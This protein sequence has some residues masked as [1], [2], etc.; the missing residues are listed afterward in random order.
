MKNVP[1]IHLHIPKAAGNTLTSL[2]RKVFSPEETFICGNNE[3]GLNHYQ[4]NVHFIQMDDGQ[5]SR[6]RFIA[7]HVEFALI[8]S[9]PVRHFSFTFMRN[10][11]SRINSLYYYIMQNERHHLHATVVDEGHSIE[12][13]CEL[14]IWHELDNGMCRR[15]SGV[16]DS[17]PYGECTPEVLA[18][19]KYNLENNISFVGIHER[20]NE[21]LFLLLHALDA[22][23]L[24][25]YD[26]KNVTRKKRL[27]R[28][29]SA[30][31]KK[32]LDR[33]N[34][35]DLELYAHARELYRS[36]NQ[37]TLTALRKPLSLYL[38]AKG[39]QT[40]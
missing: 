35:Y 16:A 39:R 37:D 8:Q 15:I 36:R 5:K 17:I 3:F 34:R 1:V 6:Y 27:D 38:A 20:F 31:T 22:V 30:S 18:A 7:G 2:F 28:E 23:E 19:A 25:D 32:A 13:L 24:L 29:L 11:L 26:K 14:G 12:S 10:P 40:N 33:F 21:S 4:S 9:Y